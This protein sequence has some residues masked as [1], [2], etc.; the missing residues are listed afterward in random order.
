MEDTPEEWYHTVT[1]KV[2]K[3]AYICIHYYLEVKY[4][5]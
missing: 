3:R 1:N 2:K 4:D 5:I